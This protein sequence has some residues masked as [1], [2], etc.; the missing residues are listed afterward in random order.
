MHTQCPHCNTLFNISE[1]QLNAANGKV[2]CGFCYRIFNAQ[3]DIHDETARGG[4]AQ[5]R[6][7]ETPSVDTENEELLSGETVSVSQPPNLIDT[8]DIASQEFQHVT[9]LQLDRRTAI[10]NKQGIKP[11]RTVLW[12]AASVLFVAFLIIQFGY[13]MRNDLAQYPQLRPALEKLCAVADCVIPMQRDT[14]MI[15][16]VSRDIR[17]HPTAEKVL[18]VRAI[19]TNEAPFTQPY[20]LLRLELTDISGKTVAMRDFQPEEYLNEEINIEGGFDTRKKVEIQ[21]DIVDPD[22]K[23]VGF[24]FAFL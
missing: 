24:E 7:G 12:G 1:E 5:Q 2:R 23:V 10:E 11:I 18:R 20:P 14:G 21:L 8:I 3:C 22:E 16:L 15:K 17:S 4:R 6:P 9:R 13:F 19:M